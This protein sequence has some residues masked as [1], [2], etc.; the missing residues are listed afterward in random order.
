MKEKFDVIKL[1]LSNFEA[2][3]RKYMTVR[4]C[5][6]APG[7]ETGV[8]LGIGLRFLRIVLMSD[9]FLKFF[10]PAERALAVVELG[11]P[12]QAIKDLCN[13]ILKLQMLFYPRRNSKIFPP[14]FVDQWLAKVSFPLPLALVEGTIRNALTSALLDFPT[15][16]ETIQ[17]TVLR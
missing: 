14:E 16:I 12:S 1:Q 11:H 3:H 6:S 17:R 5:V 10:T 2:E 4:G 8:S 13:E 7:L 9:V 15:Q